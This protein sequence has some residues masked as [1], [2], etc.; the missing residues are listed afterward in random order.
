MGIEL[1]AELAEVAAATGVSW[2]QADESAMREQAAAWRDAAEDLSKLAGAVDSVAGQAVSA[3]DGPAGEAVRL[4]AA[5]MADP[6]S[7][8]VSVAARGAGQAADRLE[9]AAEQV[10]AA[11]VEMV[12][13]LVDAAKNQDVARGAAEAGHPTALLGVDTMLNGTRAN[14]GAVADGLAG[15]VGPGDSEDGEA[16]APLVDVNPGTQGTRGQS[17]LLGAATGLPGSIVDNGL[18]TVDQTVDEMVGEDGT[19]GARLGEAPGHGGLA[20]APG[21]GEDA[22]FGQPREFNLGGLLEQEEPDAVRQ[23]DDGPPVVDPAPAEAELPATPPI[24]IPAPTEPG[25]GPIG[26]N[27]PV[28]APGSYGGLLEPGGFDE[29]PTPAAGMPLS[30]GVQGPGAAPAAGQTT[31]AGFT[32][33]SG[34]GGAAPAPGAGVPGVAPAPAQPAPFAGGQQFSPGQAQFGAAPFGA[35]P[36]P[37]APGPAG[38]PV[39]PPVS[40]APGAPPVQPH[41]GAPPGPAERAPGG[42]ADPRGGFGHPGSPPRPPARWAPHAEPAPPPPGP[43]PSA[44]PPPPALGT[45]RQERAGVVALFLVHMFPIGH[46]PVAADRPARQLPPPCAEVDFAAGLRFPPHDHPQSAAIDDGQ[47]LAVLREGARQPPA[48]PASVLPNAPAELTEG[49]DPLGGLHEREWDRKFLLPVAGAVEYAWPPGELYPEGGCAEGEPVLLA[50]GTLLDRFGDATGRVF[51]AGGTSFPRRSLP[52]AHLDGGYRRY[53]VLREL[54]MWRAVSA[55]WFGQPGGGVR[56]RAVY[57]AAELV[58]LGYLA[59]STFEQPT[60]READAG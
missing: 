45:P 38:G 22:M 16:D 56:Y 1:P 24:G 43:P 49:H 14:L 32:E 51:A 50:E 55:G 8:S 25:T 54:P 12:R 48:P 37:N 47:A 20:G 23:P 5:G 57:S 44:A 21:A 34:L 4:A 6:D 36:A 46:L 39:P 35:G 53:R 2:P 3:I 9:R 10:G 29:A 18:S 19:I 52:P 60:V 7:G 41:R 27:P 26:M 30:P 42:P 58:L 33:L 28:G 11:K 40:G 59:D 13:Q 15:A 17:G 31:A